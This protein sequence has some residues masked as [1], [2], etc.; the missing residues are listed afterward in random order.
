VKKFLILALLAVLGTVVGCGSDT[1][2]TAASTP[3][4]APTATVTSTP[5]PTVTVTPRPTVT[6][7]TQPPP[8]VVV[9]GPTQTVTVPQPYV[10]PY[11]PPYNSGSVYTWAG[12]ATPI[13]AGIHIHIHPTTDINSGNLAEVFSWTSVGVVCATQGPNVATY[14][15]NTTRWDYV[16]SPAVGWVSDGFLNTNGPGIPSC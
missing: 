9:P 7:T 13:P 12:A 2:P 11:I 15:G 16:T 10:P 5:T 6:V 8:V 14:T 4:V 3:T 1:S